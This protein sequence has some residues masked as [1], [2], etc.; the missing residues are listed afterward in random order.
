MPEGWCRR[1]AIQITAQLPENPEDA[2]R[3]L[4]LA[5]QLVEGFLRPQMALERPEAGGAILAFPA[6]SISR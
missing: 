6:S 2:L 5:R 3:V 4:E 1:H